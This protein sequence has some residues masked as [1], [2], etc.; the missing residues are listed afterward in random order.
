MYYSYGVGPEPLNPSFLSKVQDLTGKVTLCNFTC[1]VLFMISIV[2]RNYLGEDVRSEDYPYTNPHQSSD[3]LSG[4]ENGR[5]V[6]VCFC[7]SRRTYNTII[8]E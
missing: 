2:C 8:K 3:L 1:F 7:L 5:K 6:P 4:R